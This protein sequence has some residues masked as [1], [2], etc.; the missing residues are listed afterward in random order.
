MPA[1]AKPGPYGTQPIKQL[2]AEAGVTHEQAADL[3]EV[4][5]HFVTMV[6]NGHSRPS[7]VNAA[8]LAHLVA[9]P[10]EECFTPSLLG[11]ARWPRRS[12]GGR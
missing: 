5:S 6:C 2:L 3:L 7:V 4:S 11:T 1:R 8:R 9:R 10:I 12:R